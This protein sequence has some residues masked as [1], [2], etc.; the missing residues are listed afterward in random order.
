MEHFMMNQEKEYKK[1]VAKDRDI[2]Q[3]L[4]FLNN[5]IQQIPNDGL[6]FKNYYLCK[7]SGSSTDKILLDNNS[8]V[9]HD[10]INDLSVVSNIIDSGIYSLK[11]QKIDSFINTIIY[12]YNLMCQHDYIVDFTEFD[13]AAATPPVK[14]KDTKEYKIL[15]SM[16]NDFDKLKETLK[17]II[18]NYKSQSH[19]FICASYCDI[20]IFS[21][22]LK[23]NIEVCKNCINNIISSSTILHGIPTA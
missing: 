19:M 11:L 22:T 14:A 20:K 3:Y 9:T 4:N 1:E 8:L 12:L 21:D 13:A 10:I 18:A 17:T 7:I 15:S 23:I 2:I 16:N 5:G 6:K